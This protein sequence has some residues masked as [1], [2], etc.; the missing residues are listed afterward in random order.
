VRFETADA[1]SP[2][3][4]IQPRPI[5]LGALIR[6]HPYVTI[7]QPPELWQPD[8]D[9][10]QFL[11][12]FGLMLVALLVRNGGKF[13]GAT[14]NVSNVVVEPLA[15][16]PVP[17]GEF[18]AITG[19]SNGNWG[20]E[21]ARRPD[22]HARPPLVSRDLESAAAAAGGVWAYTRGLGEG[23]GSVTVLFPRRPHG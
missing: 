21:I 3:T 6:A 16:G 15:E 11:R 5:D 22:R 12:F 4:V 13:D 1:N 2:M 20:P 18:V 19:I 9:D 14:V 23:R 10:V 17:L 8:S 7:E